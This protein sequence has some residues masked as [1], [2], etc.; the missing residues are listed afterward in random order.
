MNNCLIC[1]RANESI[2]YRGFVKNNGEIKLE[3]FS[4]LEEAVAVCGQENIPR[5][6][7]VQA[8]ISDVP[9]YNGSVNR[10]VFVPMCQL[11][12]LNDTIEQKQTQAYSINDEG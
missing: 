10:S 8:I 9:K 11:C 7:Q 12:S 4:S 5:Y 2:W 6:N 3:W 1:G